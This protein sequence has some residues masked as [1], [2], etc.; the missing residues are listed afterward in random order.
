[1][2]RR[3]AHNERARVP[4]PVVRRRLPSGRGAI[5][6]PNAGHD[7]AAALTPMFWLA[8]IVTGVATGLFGDVLMALLFHV[9]RLA[10]GYHS[11]SLLDGVRAASN[12]RRVVVLL[13]GGASGAV[14]WYLLRRFARGTTEVDDA[15][16]RGTG[17]LSFWRSLGTSAISE[18]VIG[19]GAS[20]GREAAPK[21][22][23][24]ASGS[25][26]ARWA[27]LSPQQRR[28]LVSCGAGAGLAAVYNVPI[29]GALFTA[30]VL[31]GSISLPVI[32]PAL[33]CSAIATQT[34]RWYLPGHQSYIGIPH[35]H[36]GASLIVWAF[37][38]GPLT[39]LLAAG[40]I[41]LIGWISYHRAKGAALLVA[42]PAAFGL[43]GLLGIAYPELFGNGKGIVGETFV[44]EGGL[45]LL[46]ALFLLKPLVTALCLGAGAS[47][48]LFTP[49]LS[50]GALFG[51]FLGLAWTHVWHGTPLGAYAM[52]GGA[53]M[54]GAAMQAP[55]AA[56]VLVIELT[57]SGLGLSIPIIAATVIA[58]AIA[59][60]LDGYS[61]YSARLPAISH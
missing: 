14:A 12:L 54:I 48:G 7:G 11:G 4:P 34:A 58:T 9:E 28:L 52:V 21:L 36:S 22:M 49:V 43:L 3:G 47:G 45:T 2:L 17:E 5:E 10:F 59:R 15:L 50:T 26:I 60:H 8:V 13:I 20:I 57:D 16:W 55:L 24:G 32:L 53:A 19:F 18:V 37:L 25:V 29:G 56:L 31:V 44:G 6:Q 61:I 39:G 41:R 30:E 51:G 35:Y 38:L 46:L 1:M 42:M 40:Y 23:G 33:A 27:R